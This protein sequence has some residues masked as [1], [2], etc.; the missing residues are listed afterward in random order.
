MKSENNH[1][2][3]IRLKTYLLLVVVAGS[4]GCAE[5]ADGGGPQ[6]PPEPDEVLK[7]AL[8]TD[9]SGGLSE[10]GMSIRDGFE[11][12]IDHINEIGVFGRPVETFI[13]DT[14]LDRDH[15]LSE[16][17]RLVALGVHGVVGAVASAVTIPVAEEV[18]APARI[19]M[20]SPGSS[21]P[22][23]TTVP[24]NDFLFRTTLSDVEQGPILALVALQQGLTNVGLIYRND[25]WGRG[26]A[27]AFETQW[28]TTAAGPLVSV[29]ID[30]GATTYVDAVRESAS[31]GAE[32]LVLLAFQP[33]QETVVRESIENGVYDQFLFGPTGRSLEL[34]RGI[35]PEHLIGMGGTG[36]GAAQGTAS[37]TAW[38]A[39]FMAEFG[40]LPGTPYAKQAYDATVALALAAQA[41]GNV[42]GV[43]I[44][45]QLRAIG[46]APGQIVLA[47]PGNVAAGLRAVAEGT[48]VDYEGA[49]QSLD[50]DANG[51]LSKGY[52]AI[53]RFTAEGTEQVTVIPFSR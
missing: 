16:A 12:A 53:W 9:L 5:I 3:L 4:A 26:I 8:L 33:E 14:R 43:A 24:D 29:A 51:D 7:L 49:A 23:L 50:W 32:A 37:A 21:S 2:W 34:L 1:L 13:T 44:R 36:P 31:Q 48:D 19:P 40:Y 52:V 46:A 38:D 6:P 45:D 10:L 35:G 25:A 17:R 27:E 11:L 28:A 22:G 20:L 15:A 30:P 41:A 47:G 42:D 39:A 18:I